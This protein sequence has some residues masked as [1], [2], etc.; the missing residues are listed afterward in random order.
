MQNEYQYRILSKYLTIT[1]LKKSLK[2]VTVSSWTHTENLLSKEITGTSSLEQNLGG[3]SK[4][5]SLRRNKKSFKVLA[6][7]DLYR[8]INF[9]EMYLMQLKCVTWRLNELSGYGN[10][11]K[12]LLA[13]LLTA[14][15]FWED[16]L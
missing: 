8:K 9:R 12:H 6:A 13:M 7:P 16:E 2:M 3:N 15:N 11:E 4:N 5:I 1:F 14:L 10:F